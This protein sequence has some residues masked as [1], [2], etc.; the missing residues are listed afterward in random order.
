MLSV[1]PTPTLELILNVVVIAHKIFKREGLSI[2][3]M[4]NVDVV[5]A[6]LGTTITV[7]TVKGK[8]IHVV[9]P[10]CTQYADRLVVSGE[11]VRTRKK[12]GDF[13]LIVKLIT[14][15]ALSERQ[16]SILVEFQNEGKMRKAA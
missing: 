10:E 11:G 8:T 13:I 14:P 4:I 1:R 12:V 6:M 7:E 3:R 15:T 2:L 9:V 5:D 16:R